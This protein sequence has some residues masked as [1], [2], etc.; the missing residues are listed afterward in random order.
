MSSQVNT[1]T[2]WIF[3][4]GAIGILVAFSAGN[5]IA[6]ENYTSIGLILGAMAGLLIFFGFGKFGFLLIP[7]CYRLTGQI[8][9]I[10]LPFG[11]N[12]LVI[13]LASIVFV[14]GIIFKRGGGK[15]RFEMIDL[16]AWINIGYLTTVFFR[17][18]VGVR[19]LGSSLVG[20][21]PYVD[22]ILGVMAYV[23]LSRCRIDARQARSI[24]WWNMALVVGS[25]LIATAVVFVPSLGAVLGKFYSAFSSYGIAEDDSPDIEVGETRLVTLLNAGLA[26]ILYALS[27]V[28][29]LDFL[30]A[31]SLKLF[32]GYLAGTIMVLLSG[33]RNGIFTLFALTA[34]GGVIRDKFMGAVKIAFLAFL[35]AT[36]FVGL[37]FL[38]LQLPLTAQRSLSFLPGDWDPRAT[39]AADGSTEWRLH[40]WEVALASDKYI[41]NR[42]LGDGFGFTMQ[43]FDI[44]QN[45]HYRVGV[46]FSGPDAKIESH[47]IQGSFHSGP[48]SAVKRVGYLGFP[49]LLLFMG[50]MVAYC[51]RL[52]RKTRGG[53]FELITLYFGMPMIIL[54][55]TYFF[56]FGQYEDMN[57]MLFSLGMMK[58]IEASAVSEKMQLMV[59]EETR[60]PL[61]ANAVHP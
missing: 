4:I 16:V 25:G 34:L 48:L 43:E 49:L 55:P 40:M 32:A 3:L 53:D 1:R 26:L 29:P 10:P 14:S 7:I 59:R 21:K 56:I 5:S 38:G 41:R 13:I 19:A 39:K 33:F 42:F 46:G 57:V 44:M 37:S 18:P 24:P 17:N 9:V 2:L 15:A 36:S 12:E 61:P 6:D 51:W 50:M 52:I 31:S 8:S 60:I 22:F 45:D 35:L 20:G 27:R 58:M 23:I 47:L 11:V 54:P 30:R 28:S